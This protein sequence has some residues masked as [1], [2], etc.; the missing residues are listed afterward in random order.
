M[1]SADLTIIFEGGGVVS[2]AASFCQITVK[3]LAV[4]EAPGWS[5]ANRT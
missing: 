1:A 5:I 3:S 4:R 2:P